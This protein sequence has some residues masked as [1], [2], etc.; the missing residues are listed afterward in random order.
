MKA[1]LSRE[2][3]RQ[4]HG[5]ARVLMQQGRVLLDADWNEQV[6][7]LLEQ[8]RMLAADLIGP[9]GGPGDGFRITCSDDLLCDFEIGRGRYYV[10]GI[11]CEL[12]PEVHCSPNGDTPPVLYT[13][14]AD[15]P[16]AE[17]GEFELSPGARYLVYLDVWE[18]H[19]NHLQADGICEL[20]LGGSDTA[21]RAKVV[22]QVKVASLE[23][24]EDDDLGCEDLLDILVGDRLKL[25]RCL[26]ARAKVD[27]PSEDPC[28]VPPTA[29]YRGAEN[30]L[31]RVEIHNPGAVGGSKGQATFKWS[32]ENGSVVFGIQSLQGAVAT[33]V[34]LGPDQARGLKEGDWV[35]I[36]DDVSELTA[37]PRPLYAIEAVDRVN[38]AVTLHVPEGEELPVFSEGADTHPIL[39]RWDQ[40]SAAIPVQESKWIELED[41][42]QIWFEQGGDYKT[43]DYWQIPARTAIAD[44][45]WP[46]ET[47]PD[48]A[49]WPKAQPPRGIRHH[50]APLRQIELDENGRVTCAEEECRCVFPMLCALANDERPDPPDPDPTFSRVD[51]GAIEFEA[52]TVTPLEASVATLSANVTRIRTSLAAGGFHQVEVRSLS[53]ESGPAGLA[54]GKRRED[55]VAESY[56]EAG[57]PAA[58][59]VRSDVQIVN[60]GNPRVESVLAQTATSATDPIERP[61]IPV[62]DV[63]GVGNTSAE[64]LIA[65]GIKDAAALAR[66]DLDELVEILGTPGGRAFPRSRAS[67]I[68]REAR[69]LASEG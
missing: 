52:E 10:N 66:V 9:H 20:A 47:G 19:L 29:Q 36:V 25:P 54:L 57:V 51:L 64:R 50:L 69:R 56:L 5:Y 58:S 26:R 41:G 38:A 44:V 48:G 15:F 22:C 11:A 55:L 2:S 28:L 12:W 7:I 13:M 43:G 30:Q 31:Y 3:Y 18:R 59:I 21:T 46:Q 53:V 49:P 68:I 8:T 35:E 34:S 32:R 67:E 14:Q 17:G 6:S 63:P 39:R 42:V 40:S 1:D 23:K 65:A 16:V 4:Q 45:L 27:I 60:D 33:L 37:N 61:R 62:N 24:V